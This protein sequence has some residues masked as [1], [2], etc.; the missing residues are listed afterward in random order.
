MLAPRAA[1]IIHEA[2]LAVRFGLTVYDLATTLHVYPT[3]SD[4][5]RLAAL[6]YLKQEKRESGEVTPWQ[7]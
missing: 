4:G 5:L 7:P 1:D 3:L 2:V 6:A